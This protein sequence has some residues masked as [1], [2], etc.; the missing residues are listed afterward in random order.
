MANILVVGGG[1]REHALVWKLA[2]S[3]TRPRLF[4][5]PG[6][7]GIAAPAEC[8]PI[9]AEDVAGIVAAAREHAIDL[10]VI[11]PEAPLM[12]GLADTLRAAGVAAFGP[13]AAAARLEGSKAFAKDLMARAGIPTAR[14]AAFDDAAAAR[15]YVE[16]H[17]APVV[18]KADGLAAG[19][20]V[21]VARTVAEALAAV[22]DAMERGVF[23]AAGRAVV[24]EE[25]L[26]GDELSMMALVASERFV[27]LPPSQDHKQ[28]YDGDRGPNT[29]G[30]GA[31]APVPWAD[32]AL[33]AVVRERI[34]A[35]LLRELSRAGLDYRGVIYAGLMV[36]R[37]GPQVIE[38]NARFGDPET[39][40]TLPLLAG[41]F[42][43][44]CQAVAEGRLDAAALRVAP[45]A[46]VGVVLAS[47]GYPGA[48]ATGYPI[49]GLDA[50]PP[51][52]L[53]FHAG[54]RMADN[55][56]LVTAG[57]RVLTLVGLGDDLAAARER[58]Y[59]AAARMT[60]AGVHYRRDIGLRE[61]RIT[62]LTAEDAED[63]EAERFTTEETEETE[64]EQGRSQVT[65]I[66]AGGDSLHDGS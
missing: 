51:G 6:N 12:A 35:P 15:A 31:F 7:P 44:V 19:K 62:R 27:L 40:V 22:D 49:A 8:L 63:A 14:Y 50:L 48:Y 55:G 2:Q 54:T 11:G 13:G 37:E 10:V 1:A 5:A 25:Y 65:R 24:I 28:V 41:D 34:F 32:E 20:G 36:T 4:A 17:G 30:M 23:G 33:L 59:A 21:T 57:G 58:A 60:F 29:G 26:E 9:G 64:A 18:V 52:T 47:R 42:A 56:T 16:R 45:G 43:A 3:E 53:A 61:R 39:Q 46:A 66:R 38:F